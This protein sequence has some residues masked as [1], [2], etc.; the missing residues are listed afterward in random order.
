[1]TDGR[2]AW[3]VKAAILCAAGMLLAGC[4]GPQ[5]VTHPAALKAEGGVLFVPFSDRENYYYDSQEGVGIAEAAS[6]VLRISAKRLT[7]VPYEAVR[8]LVRSSVMEESV[9]WKAVGQAAK[10]NYVVHGAINR[11]AW[12]D[13]S[14]PSIPRCIF[15]V[16][17]GVYDV[18]VGADSYRATRSGRYPF[19][20]VADKGVT[21]YEMGPEGLRSRALIYIGRV[22]SRTFYRATISA[23]ENEALSSKEEQ[24]PR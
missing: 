1:M 2:V 7:P 17:Y 10:A 12:N 19:T 18:A 16:T 21:V 14:E 22:V 23:A 20:L 8:G 9:D 3:L 13:P 24:L 5:P 6:E 11:I 4:L 15:T